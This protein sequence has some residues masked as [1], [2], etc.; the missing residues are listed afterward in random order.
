ML[1]GWHSRGAGGVGEVSTGWDISTAV[2]L[3]SFSVAAKDT[4]STGVTFKP[5][6]LK[7]YVIGTSSDSV[8]EYD[9]STAWDISTAV[10]LQSFSVAAKDAASTDVTFKPDGL[11]MYVIGGISDSVHEYN[12]ST[13]WD[14][15]TAVFLQSFS[16]SAKETIPYGVT[17]KPDGLKMYVIG[18]SSDSVHEYD[19]LT[20]WDISTAVFLQ[21]F[22]V[23]AKEGGPQGVTF[24]P[25]G[26]K[27][28]VIG[29]STRSVHEY[30]LSTA[31]DISTAVFLQSFSVGSQER[32][33]SSVTFKPDGL[34]MY[35]IG[36]IS[37]S[38]HEYNL[39]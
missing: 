19:L 26:L 35:V 15:S 8:H 30:D 4:N 39:G 23:A 6:G 29:N 27:M 20:G 25:D 14:I 9:L 16:V 3:Q 37:D 17:F 5:D 36:G 7:M 12:L 13:G 2:F 33:P 11:K 22:S 24:K 21:S 31:W 1:A 34:K 28:Y 18:F 32:S 38:V 10:F